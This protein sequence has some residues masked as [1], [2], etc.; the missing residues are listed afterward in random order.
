MTTSNNEFKIT[1][2][3]IE[4]R[5]L[6]NKINLIDEKEF[7]SINN[8]INNNIKDLEEKYEQLDDVASPI[9]K[10]EYLKGL[11]K[12][13]NVEKSFENILGTI[14]GVAKCTLDAFK[15]NGENLEDILKLMK[16]LVSIENDLY[17]QLEDNDCSKENIANLLNDFCS[18]Y[19]ID[20]LAIEG[21]FEQSFKRTIT[22]KT[23]INDLREEILERISKYEEKFDHFDETIQKKEKEFTSY[24]DCKT[25]EYKKQLEFC[26]KD[27]LIIIDKYRDELNSV[28]HSYKQEI[29]SVKYYL[30]D[31]IKQYNTEVS[32]Q[33]NIKFE[34][35]ERENLELKDQVNVLNQN[36]FKLQNRLIWNF[37]ISIIITIIIAISL[38]TY[39]LT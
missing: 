32:K 14:Q 39:F 22:L 15:A 12:T 26:I 10:N 3:E 33:H 24:F 8:K 38:I 7:I 18:Q 31:S 20:S 29:E 35:L 27:S 23:R 25:T 16:I 2:L 6:V 30:M 17:K 11:I 28:I 13:T 36:I 34:Q 37:T 4:R 9:A 1:S 19:N 21:L 5:H